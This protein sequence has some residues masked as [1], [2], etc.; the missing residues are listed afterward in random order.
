[1]KRLRLQVMPHPRGFR[2]VS[3]D[4]LYVAR[5][6]DILDPF[7]MLQHAR[8]WAEF[9]RIITLEIVADGVTAPL[10]VSAEDRDAWIAANG[11]EA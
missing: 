7:L 5:P 8:R 9:G 11:G 4:D 2:V 1:M 3:T 6:G 10:S